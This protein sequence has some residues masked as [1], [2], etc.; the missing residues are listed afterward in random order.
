MRSGDCQR[1]EH[2]YLL[3]VNEEVR[4]GFPLL[5]VAVEDF[6]I[7][8]ML[9]GQSIRPLR[10]RWRCSV[11]QYNERRSPRGPLKRVTVVFELLRTKASC[12]YPFPAS[13]TRSSFYLTT[14]TTDRRISL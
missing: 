6:K 10:K 8:D 5:G 9:Q 12:D 7:L 14:Y 13:H 11:M 2:P 4:P 3:V 1:G